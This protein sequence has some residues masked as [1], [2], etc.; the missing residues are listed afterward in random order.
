MEPL[1]T[2]LRQEDRGALGQRKLRVLVADDDPDTA[3]SMAQLCEAFGHDVM[4]AADGP[5]ALAAVRQQE[6]DVVLLD[7]GLPKINGYEVA[8]GL[9]AADK[10]PFLL[11]VTG[12]GGED[13]RRRCAEAGID[14]VLIK[15]ADPLLL[16][17]FLERLHTA[18]CT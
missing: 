10:R 3:S 12:F 13:H 11:A 5:A 2:A 16:R 17:Q 8:R 18:M 7:I 9:R 15:P 1:V 4:V 6:P 14:L